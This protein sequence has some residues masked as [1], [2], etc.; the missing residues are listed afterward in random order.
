MQYQADVIVIGAGASGC[1]AAIRAAECHANT[2]LIEKNEKIGRKLYITGKGRCNLTNSCSEEDFQ[3]KVVHNG[4]FLYSALHAFNTADTQKFFEK[5]GVPL[6]IERGNRVFPVS[7]RSADIVDALLRALRRERVKIIQDQVTELLVGVENEIRGVKSERNEYFA[8]RVIVATG[9]LSYPKTGSTGD[10]YRFAR[11]VGHT[12]RPPD[13]A[14]VPLEMQEDC[15]RQM[16]GLSLRNVRLSLHD[17]RGKVLYQNRGEMLFTHFGISGPLVLSASSFLSSKCGSC[18]IHIDLKPA[19]DFPKLEQ[20]VL[21]EVKE[22]PNWNFSRL[23]GEYLPRKMISI[24]PEYAGIPA[25]KKLN[26]ITKEERTKFVV[27]LKDFI[28]NVKGKRPIE[29]AIITAGGIDVRE[30]RPKTME[31]KYVKGLYFTGEVLD[32]DAVT[33]G[34]NLQIAW[35]T[36]YVAGTDAGQYRTV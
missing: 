14:L 16:Q 6:K 32:V 8:C 11:E 30:I 4:K 1:M 25:D 12:V 33:G 24:F 28:L 29:E 5:Q 15:C 7:D 35:S 22:H 3:S 21:R 9:G 34:F 2:I 13:A 23:L 19:L 36:G 20:R 26:S 17:E 31:S 27:S 10:G 18:T